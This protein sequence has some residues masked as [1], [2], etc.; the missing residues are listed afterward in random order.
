MDVP[1][2]NEEFIKWK[3]PVVIYLEVYCSQACAPCSEAGFLR[4]QVVTQCSL[5][6]QPGLALLGFPQNLGIFFFFCRGTSGQ[7]VCETRTHCAPAGGGPGDSPQEWGQ[8][9]TLCASLAC[10]SLGAHHPSGLPTLFFFLNR[11]NSGSVRGLRHQSSVVSVSKLN[12][13]CCRR[14]VA[15]LQFS[16]PTEG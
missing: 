16:K 2:N 8:D 7:P 3:R 12:C 9:R 1:L 14:S 15:L 5:W 10:T 4:L 6:A 13:P 11:H